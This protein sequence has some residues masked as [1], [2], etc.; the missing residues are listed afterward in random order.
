MTDTIKL[1][2]PIGS[3]LAEVDSKTASITF[4]T[5]EDCDSFMLQWIVEAGKKTT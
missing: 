3:T 2:I 4:P 1:D 5:E